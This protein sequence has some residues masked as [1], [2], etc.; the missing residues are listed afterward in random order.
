MLLALLLVVQDEYVELDYAKL[1]RAIAREPAYAGTPHYALIV[2]DPAGKVRSWAVVDKSAAGDVLYFDLDGDGDLT[3]AGERF[4]PTDQG[5]LI[6]VGAWGKHTDLE[7]TLATRRTTAAW[8]RMKYGGKLE[9]SGG[10][11]LAGLTHTMWGDSPK[12]APVFRPCPGAP[13]AF[14]LWGE[15]T[16]ARGEENT[17]TL[18]AGPEGSTPDALCSIASEHL[19]EGKDRIVAT[20]EGRDAGGRAVSVRAEIARH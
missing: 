10:W 20:L 16:L 13:V 8:F 7:F 3:E 2:P 5:R 19:V 6:R 11:P 4:T 18:V 9:V 12:T 15:P 1:D 17:I 14:G